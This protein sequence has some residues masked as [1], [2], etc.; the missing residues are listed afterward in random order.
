MDER[1]TDLTG[2]LAAH[3]RGD[4]EALSRLLPLVYRDLQ[5]LAKRQ[6]G[7]RRVG[8][9]LDTTSL[10]HEAYMKLAD[11]DRTAWEN[12][13]HFFAVASLAMRQIVI[14][15][16]RQSRAEK[17]GGE[18]RH[19]GLDQVAIAIDEQAEGLLALDRA[20]ER[21]REIDERLPRV[22]ECRFFT[23]LSEEETA[24][25]LG[26]STR[27][28]ERDWKRARAWLRQELAPA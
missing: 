7:H 28:V 15:Y 25:A 8:Q 27:T 9:T 19:V 11:G 26:V 3:R 20:L 18:Q 24:E 22:V 14:D 4:R 10:V 2:L 23:G 17:R 6:L 16:A 5:R 1:R 21:L 12:R 13:G